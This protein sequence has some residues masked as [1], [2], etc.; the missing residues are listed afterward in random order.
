MRSQLSF[1]DEDQSELLKTAA[2][3]WRTLPEFDENG[4]FKEDI[5][6]GGLSPRLKLL[7]EMQRLAFISM[8]G[9]DLL[10]HKLTSYQAGDLWVPVGGI[11][12][13]DMDIPAVITLLLVG[14]T[15]SGKSSLVNFMYSVLGRSGLIPFAQTSSQPTKFTTMLLEEH[16]VLRSKKNG[17]CVYDTRG[18]D[19]HRMDEGMEDVWSWMSD[20]VRHNQPCCRGSDDDREM[21]E[22]S[23]AGRCANKYCKRRVNCVLVVADM[24]EAFKDFSSG[25]LKHVEAI[26]MIFHSPSIR[27]S[28]EKPMLILTHGDILT[29]EERVE[30]RLKLCESLGIS[31][32]TGAYDI[33][34]LSES[35][36]PAEEGDPVSAFALT[37]AVYRS[38]LQSD[39]THLPKRKFK[40]W[41]LAFASWVLCCFSS[42]FAMLANFFSRFGGNNKRHRLKIS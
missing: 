13:T 40:D 30:T 27:R 2:W 9:L 20:G 36:I 11:K 24:E 21:M 7:R 17:F 5:S 14:L 10:R 33:A 23:M 29:A 6:S 1:S 26:K 22:Y 42:F 41:V 16:N 39:R 38:L 12:K 18:L 15:G 3:W 25:D 37:E 34:C 28:N 4:R 35:G 31:E 19:C 32:T 8:E